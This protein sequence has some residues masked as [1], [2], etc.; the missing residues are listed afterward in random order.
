M[1]DSDFGDSS[2]NLF[3][4]KA[5]HL[6]LMVD[7]NSSFPISIYN[8]KNLRSLL[9]QFEIGMNSFDGVLLELLGKNTCLRALAMG[10]TAKFDMMT[11]VRFSYHIKLERIP[12]EIKKLIHLRYLD[13]SENAALE[14]LPEELCELCNLQTL[15]VYWCYNLKEL[16]QGMGKLIN[17][18]HLVNDYTNSLRYMPKGI[19][20]L[21]CLQ[22]LSEF[23]VSG[24]DYHRKACSLEFL[25]QFG[26]LEGSLGI[27]GLGNVTNVSEAQRI[28]LRNMENIFKL[29]L[30]FDGSDSV[31]NEAI[32]EALQPPPNL[33]E[34]M[35]S[36][37]A[38]STVLPNWIVSLTNLRGI[39][40]VE[41][42]NSEQLPPLGKVS[43]L[44]SIL[45]Q[46]MNRVKR[47]GIEI[48]GLESDGITLSSSSLSI[49]A[50]PKLKSLYFYEMEEWEEWDFGIED[51]NITIL[52]SL[53]L[54]EIGD[55]PKL[56]VLPKK[57]LQMAPLEILSIYRCPILSESYRKGTGE[58]W[59]Y[60]S[61]I[62]NIQIDRQFVQR[63]C[64]LC[65]NRSRLGVDPYFSVSLMKNYLSFNSSKSNVRAQ[66]E[67]A[68]FEVV[69]LFRPT[70]STPGVSICRKEARRRCS[71]HF[72]L[73]GCVQKKRQRGSIGRDP[74]TLLAFRSSLANHGFIRFTSDM[75]NVDIQI[76][77]QLW[78]W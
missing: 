34:L 41:W 75:L 56:K 33:H 35:I 30:S 8:I 53:R 21:T 14:M 38:G 23:R 40:L 26:H 74:F 24:S 25:N 60:I 18:R 78:L 61:H 54:L 22:T 47:V 44:E 10:G 70:C 6:S 45:I 36:E 1:K 9:F 68:S 43:S 50:F 3:L 37:Y 13:L 4:E 77:N 39:S 72:F 66:K 17:L 63:D 31:N 52:P 7:K 12:K 27:V 20:K 11:G 28:Q 67:F 62:P 29:E 19:E 46:R 5:G 49:S 32:I 69:H 76:M 71:R 48:L 59:S 65:L 2:I 55:C 16:P 42:I 64:R 15:N 51:G 57:I 58:N 73:I